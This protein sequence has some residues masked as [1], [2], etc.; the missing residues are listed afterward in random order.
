[1]LPE[2]SSLIK[3]EDLVSCFQSIYNFFFMIFLTL[4]FISFVYGAFQYL[5]SGA[6]IFNKEAGKKRMI[7][8]IVAIIVVLLI[9]PVLKLINPE[10]F[11]GIKLQ[12]PKIKIESP[13]IYEPEGEDHT[14][15]YEGEP[16]SKEFVKF[17]EIDYKFEKLTANSS[18]VVNR[19]IVDNL[20]NLDICLK[21]N[22]ISAI[23]TSG[24]RGSGALSHC[25]KLTGT[26]IDIITN[27]DCDVWQKL[28]GC[29]R[30]SG[31]GDRIIYEDLVYPKPAERCRSL[32]ADRCKIEWRVCVY[33]TG[34]HIHAVF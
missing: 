8:S 15:G 25:H 22:N 3:C 9:P 14:I 4:A 30:E 34:R 26:C 10:I 5:I 21:N 12:I 18:V 20:I 33:T 32:G 13:I 19:S 28:G 27:G 31:A 29:L 17:S 16:P 24:L 11:E 2:P 1:M 7:N 23:I 6:G